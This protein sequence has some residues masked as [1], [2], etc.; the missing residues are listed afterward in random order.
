[1]TEAGSP[2]FLLF[3]EQVTL[4]RKALDDLDQGIWF[5]RLRGNMTPDNP[6]NWFIAFVPSAWGHWNDAVYGVHF[7]FMYAPQRGTKAERIRLAIG[8]ELPMKQ[9][10]RRP[11]KE[12]VAATVASLGI[13]P[14]AFT[15]STMDR[16]KMLE[17]DP[18]P[19]NADSWR[20]AM[21]R[22]D[23]LQPIIAVVAEVVREYDFRGAFSIPIQF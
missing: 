14:S 17:V 4:F 2:R 20:V 18:I 10:F 23:S 7:D 5:P 3:K 16:T 21:D 11:F 8:V 19:F 15:L 6:G 13:A 22:Y 12:G 1:M 9:P